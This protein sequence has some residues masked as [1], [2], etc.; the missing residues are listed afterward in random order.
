MKFATYRIVASIDAYGRLFSRK[1]YIKTTRPDMF[2][3]VSSHNKYVTASLIPTSST[4]LNLTMTRLKPQ[5]SPSLLW[6][7]LYQSPLSAKS[8]KLSNQRFGGW[9]HT[10]R[11][12]TS[13]G[14]VSQA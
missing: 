2:R 3:I 5:P 1:D 14:L 10:Y 12:V 7:Y 11:K 9:T 4:G 6:I 8:F 13:T